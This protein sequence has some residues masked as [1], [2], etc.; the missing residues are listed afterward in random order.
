MTE[1]GT[2]F[3][4]RPRGTAPPTIEEREPEPE[5]SPGHFASILPGPEG[6]RLFKETKGRLGMR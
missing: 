3:M 2:T 1:P 6:P 4:P 5:P